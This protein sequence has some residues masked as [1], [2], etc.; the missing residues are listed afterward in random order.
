MIFVALKDQNERNNSR[1]AAFIEL[2]LA[3]P[4]ILLLLGAV[5]G[6]GAL[7]HQ[8]FWLE[9]TAYN[10]SLLSAQLAPRLTQLEKTNRVISRMGQ[11]SQV[12]Q[13]EYREVFMT[14]NTGSNL[15][16][17]PSGSN[18]ATTKITFT[19]DV[20]SSN[21]SRVHAV[22]EAPVL[23]PNNLV[24]S[25]SDFAGSLANGGMGTTDCCGRYGT[26]P[27]GSCITGVV[28]DNSACTIDDVGFYR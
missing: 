9:Q 2:A 11:L 25:S 18:G 17:L 20:K 27:L 13:G 26:A 10:G 24:A 3:M 28:Y 16:I 7:I 23:S 15:Q 4:V 6:A 8:Y 5:F 22:V 14:T 12:H 1:G 21:L 19:G